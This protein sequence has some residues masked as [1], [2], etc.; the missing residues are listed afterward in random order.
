M[1]DGGSVFEANQNTRP[2]IDIYVTPGVTNH[3]KNL[4]HVAVNLNDS[5]EIDFLNKEIEIQTSIILMPYH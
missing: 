2:I 5:K 1:V 4:D 3:P